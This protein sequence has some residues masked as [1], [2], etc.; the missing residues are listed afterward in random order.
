LR[1]V[2]EAS[3]TS[4]GLAPFPTLCLL[5]ESSVRSRSWEPPCALIIL[6]GSDE[7]I[8]RSQKPQPCDS[9]RYWGR[10]GM[11]RVGWAPCSGREALNE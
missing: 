2:A 4:D 7:S 3:A 10:F 5:P 1:E 6:G 8:F 9:A 11:R